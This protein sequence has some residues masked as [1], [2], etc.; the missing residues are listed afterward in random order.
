MLMGG[1]FLVACAAPPPPPPDPTVARLSIRAGADSNA[2][3]DGQG[4][5]VSVHVFAL[6][7]GAAFATADADALLGRSP[8]GLPQTIKPLG[9]ETVLP[10]RTVAETYIMPDGTNA[11]GVAVDFRAFATARW[12]VTAPVPANRTTLV[13]MAIGTNAI[14]V[15]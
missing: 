3:Q 12:R 11:I 15:E 8:G 4:R 7:P 14:S 9:T 10:G 2:A 5:P 1:A 6:T 13:K